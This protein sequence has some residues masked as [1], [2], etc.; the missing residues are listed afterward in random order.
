MAAVTERKD[1][2]SDTRLTKAHQKLYGLSGMEQYAHREERKPKQDLTSHL[3]ITF[4]YFLSFAVLSEKFAISYQHTTTS[5]TE[6]VLFLPFFTALP[7][8]LIKMAKDIKPIIEI[9]QKGDDFVVTSKTPK[10][11]VTN[12]FTLGKEADITTM[13]GKKLKVTD[14]RSGGTSLVTLVLPPLL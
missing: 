3:D 14:F 2:Y 11:S 1:M 8:E 5:I 4:Y 7:D 9:K 10:Q 6:K 13:D 12:S